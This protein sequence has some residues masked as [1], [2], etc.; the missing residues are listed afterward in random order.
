MTP[1]IP[2]FVPDLRSDT[3]HVSNGRI[4]LRTVLDSAASEHVVGSDVDANLLSPTSMVSRVANGSEARSTGQLTTTTPFGPAKV[5]QIPGCP[6]T[7][8]SLPQLTGMGYKFFLQDGGPSLMIDPNLKALVIPRSKARGGVRMWHVDLLLDP[9]STGSRNHAATW[10][11]GGMQP[12]AEVYSIVIDDLNLDA[13]PDSDLIPLAH[14]SPPT[15]VGHSVIGTE[16]ATRT[17]S[18]FKKLSGRTLAAT[19]A[20]PSQQTMVAT[21]RSA[22]GWGDLPSK[23]SLRFGQAAGVHHRLKVPKQLPVDRQT[24]LVPVDVCFDLDIVPLSPDDIQGCSCAALFKEHRSAYLKPYLLSTAADFWVAVR[25]LAAW[26]ERV[27][28]VKLMYLFADSDPRW[29]TGGS[30]R[31]T[32][33]KRG[34]SER[35]PASS[36]AGSRRIRMLST[37]RTASRRYAPRATSWSN[38]C[39]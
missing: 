38:T 12:D 10:L 18:R 28:R 24:N 2:L 5:Y 19:Y 6:V 35:R 9:D 15:P 4:R 39:T 29:T 22:I 26:V 13:F 32:R 7:L 34:C 3:F 11:P 1:H 33:L 27:L 25:S 14:S 8:S 37:P 21:A 31:S 30:G 17:P 36:S 23:M 16:L 20:F